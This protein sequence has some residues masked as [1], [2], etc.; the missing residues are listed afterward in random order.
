MRVLKS[1]PIA[2]NEE[3]RPVLSRLPRVVVVVLAATLLAFPATP[4]A[5]G[6]SAAPVVSSITAGS[7][8]TCVVTSTGKAMCWGQNV[9]GQLGNG[10]TTNSLTP[11]EVSGLSSGVTTAG[12]G[13]QH[14]CA[15]TTGGGVK[16]W[17]NN[18][19]GRLGNGSTTFSSTP[20]DVAG[21]SSGVT[22]IAVGSSHACALTSR[23]GV[24]CWGDNSGGYGGM[25]GDG[26]TTD[27][28]TPVDV[29]GLTSGVTAIAA[30]NGHTCAVMTGGTVKCWGN[31]EFGPLGNGSTTSSTIPVDVVGLTGGVTAIGTGDGDT[32]ALTTG[33]GIKCW[34]E[35]IGGQLGNGSTSGIS[36]VVDVVGLAS[37]VTAIAVGSFH[38][39]ALTG[40][41]GVKC[42]GWNDYGQ[43]GNGSMTYQIYSP[44]A[45]SGLASG[46][47]TIAAG[48]RHTCAALNGGG[49][50][51]WG[52]GT[53]GQLG[54][55]S[56][57]NSSTPVDV[58]FSVGLGLTNAWQAKVGTSGVNGTA[59]ISR[60]TNGTGAIALKFVKLRASTT[61][62]VVVHKGTCASVGPVIFKLA[63]IKTSSSGAAARKNALTVAQMNLV[64]AA[65]KGTGKIAIRVGSGASTK[66]GAFA[67]L[68]VP[69]PQAVVQSFYNWYIAQAETGAVN[70]RGRPDLTPAFIYWAEHYNDGEMFGA[71]AVLCAQSIPEWVKTAPALISGSSATVEVTQ[72]F[73]EPYVI[74]VGLTRGTAGWQIATGGC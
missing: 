29:V 66:C 42:W 1:K 55:G 9:T 22:A 27:R 53:V 10:T 26:S 60:Y 34:G 69:G 6:A 31:N 25:L 38:T 30:G 18:S 2:V 71:D 41:G 15:V 44:V 59:K 56:T 12:A 48:F 47:S 58:V 23:G 49:V 62:P 43:V 67:K 5:T 39:C 57:T 16:C 24:K 61:L 72:G 32:C 21:L 28:T 54:N 64:L 65:T 13:E 8:H 51:C 70:L 17:G 45:V 36:G 40:A 4:V 50:K 74:T 14:T 7:R 46:V 63:S 11:V 3:A 73:V 19:N 37:G 20:V 35:N 52:A 68:A 33:G